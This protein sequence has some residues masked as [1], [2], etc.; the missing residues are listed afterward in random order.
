MYTRAIKGYTEAEGDHEAEAEGDHE[1]DI[2]YLEKRLA[3]LSTKDNTP[4]SIR[5]TAH[6]QRS[7]RLPEHPNVGG[8]DSTARRSKADKVLPQRPMRDR[9]LGLMKKR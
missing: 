8:A 2:K 7:S 6:Q 3:L 9:L 5:G 4:S 1:A